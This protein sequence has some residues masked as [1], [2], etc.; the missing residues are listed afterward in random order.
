M[1][2]YP[3]DERAT[4]GKGGTLRWPSLVILVVIRADTFS[5]RINRELPLWSV[6]IAIPGIILATIV[7]LYIGL[8]FSRCQLVNIYAFYFTSINSNSKLN[9][10]LAVNQ[11]TSIN[12]IPGL[13]FC[14]HCIM[15][16]IGYPRADAENGRNSPHHLLG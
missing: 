8:Y 13:D 1:Q 6:A 16:C 10:N 3:L 4:H 2:W 11:S 14:V 7:V 9:W 5:A 15:W 12:Q